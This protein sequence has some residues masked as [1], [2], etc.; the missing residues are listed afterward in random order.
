MT[1]FLELSVICLYLPEIIISNRRTKIIMT[2]SAHKVQEEGIRHAA[3]VVPISIA[4]EMERLKEIERLFE[5][6]FNLQLD[7]LR[8]ITNNHI[9]MPSNPGV[10]SEPGLV[11]TLENS[12]SNVRLLLEN[13]RG[14][15]REYELLV[16]YN[17]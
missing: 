16:G 9:E 13:Y 14:L 5:E 7:R 11:N 15:V 8:C 17:D 6:E 3:K 12:V 1:F 2:G 10:S 4:S